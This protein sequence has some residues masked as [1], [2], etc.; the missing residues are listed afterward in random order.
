MSDWKQEALFQLAI[1][2]SFAPWHLAVA[3]LAAHLACITTGGGK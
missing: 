1:A 3:L 2:L